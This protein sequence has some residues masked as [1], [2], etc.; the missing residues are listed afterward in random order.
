MN[1]LTKEYLE[2]EYVEK[3]RSFTDIAKELGTYTNRVVREAKKHGI[4]IRSK[5]EAQSAALKTGRH[6]HPTKGK[7]RTEETKVK[8]SNSVYSFWKEL[9][10]SERARRTELGRKQWESMSEQQRQEFH[11]L[12]GEAIRVASKEGS[13]LEKFVSKNLTEAGYRVEYHKEHLLLNEKMHL[14][15]F[16]PELGVAIEIDG[17]SH[18]SPIWGEEAL[19]K[20]QKADRIKSGLVLNSGFVLIRV[21][22]DKA[23][24]ERF[25]RVV[26]DQL[27]DNLQN[28]AN[29]YPPKNKR[30]IQIGA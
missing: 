18:F 4:A 7:K 12:S 8:I 9:D 14:D 28:I 19:E 26:L 11:R 25:K 16:L 22:Q 27:L 1:K 23:L 3:L 15:L 21:V 29:K 5:S 20:C 24:S 13:K 17:P 2:K 6:A 30:Y 10:D